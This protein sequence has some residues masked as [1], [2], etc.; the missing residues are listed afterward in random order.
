MTQLILELPD[1]L[2]ARLQG[3]ARRMNVPVE[4][5]VSTVLVRHFA[6]EDEDNPYDDPTDEQILAM[7]R[8]G[9]EQ[10]LAGEYRPAHE[11][12]AELKAEFSDFD[13]NDG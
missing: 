2:L 11:V 9:M 10:V 6:D 3:E 8:E 13:T 12:L 4:T 5:V 1:D 7:V